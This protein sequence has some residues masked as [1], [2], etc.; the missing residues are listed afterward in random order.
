MARI[1]LKHETRNNKLPTLLEYFKI[2]TPE[3]HRAMSDAI[4]TGL[5]FQELIKEKRRQDAFK[6]I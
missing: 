6:G 4:A 2:Y 3:S 1:L 5:L